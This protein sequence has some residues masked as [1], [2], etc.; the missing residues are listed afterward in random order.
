VKT[1]RSR[2]LRKK[3]GVFKE[4][5]AFFEEGKNEMGLAES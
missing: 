1:A 5:A 4:D 2:P 3:G